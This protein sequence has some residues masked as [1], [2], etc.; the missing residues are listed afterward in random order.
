MHTVTR[1]VE[2]NQEFPALA[3]QGFQAA[4][5]PVKGGGSLPRRPE[6][7]RLHI[8]HLP[9]WHPSPSPIP[10]FEPQKTAADQAKEFWAMNVG[11]R[12]LAIRSLL[13][14]SLALPTLLLLRYQ[15]ISSLPLI[16]LLSVRSCIN[17]CSS[18]PSLRA[19]ASLH[20][21]YRRM[22]AG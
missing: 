21:L 1:P 14:T 2:I 11:Q 22:K 12:A 16:F 10:P 9:D 7:S 4:P 8:S 18:W 6:E 13:I 3:H 19:R 5:A 20:L 17:C 15:Y